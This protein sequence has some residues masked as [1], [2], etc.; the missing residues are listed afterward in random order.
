MIAS[1][2]SKVE[3]E[4]TLFSGRLRPVYTNTFSYRFHR[5]PKLLFASSPCIYIK[6]IK[7]IIV[8]AEN[9]TFGKWSPKWKD[10][11]TIQLVPAN[12]KLP[13]IR[14]KSQFSYKTIDKTIGYCSRTIGCSQKSG[15]LFA[16]TRYIVIMILLSCIRIVFTE[17]AK[18]ENQTFE[19]DATTTTNFSKISL[20]FKQ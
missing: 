10:L 12:K 8:F 7:T 5:N 18:S 1:K 9:D 13:C 17:N 2:M 6:M 16:G 15:F 20:T 19:N 11:K 3:F 14:N 4:K